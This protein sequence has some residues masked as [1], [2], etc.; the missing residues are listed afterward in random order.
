MFVLFDFFGTQIQKIEI[1]LKIYVLK[2]EIVIEF[3][4]DYLLNKTNS[5]AITSDIKRLLPS[6]SS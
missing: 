4:I 3:E 2:L 6:L 1:I 5:F